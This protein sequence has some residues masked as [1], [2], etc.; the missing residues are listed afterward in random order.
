MGYLKMMICSRSISVEKSL[1]SS[2]ASGSESSGDSVDALFRQLKDNIL[3]G[4][5]FQELGEIFFIVYGITP[6]LKNLMF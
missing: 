6:Q 1:G 4:I 2:T 5:L 3:R